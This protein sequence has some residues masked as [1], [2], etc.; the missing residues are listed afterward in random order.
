MS[1]LRGMGVRVD[2]VGV[3][4]KSTEVWMV[5]VVSG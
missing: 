2:S 5:W 4:V 3:M 1:F